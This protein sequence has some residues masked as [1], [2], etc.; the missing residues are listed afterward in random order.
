MIPAVDTLTVLHSVNRKHAAKQF[1]LVV[2]KKTGERKIKNRSYGLEKHFRVELVALESFDDLA[3]AFDRLIDQPFAFPI[4]GG[5]LPG[6]N[7]NHTPRWKNPRQGRPATF[8]GRAH[9]WFPVD[10]DKLPAPAL[11]DPTINPTDAIEY[12]IGKLPAECHDASAWFTFTSSQGLPKA[13]PAAPDLLSARVVFWSET[14]HTD[15]ELKRW[16]RAWNDANG[17]LKIIDPCLY[18]PIQACYIA[19]PSFINMADPLNKRHGIRRGLVDTVSLIIPPAHRKRQD[20]PGTEGYD[21]GAGVEHHLNQIGKPHFRDPIVK[22]I[23]SFVGSYG[24]AASVEELKAAIGKRIDKAVKDGRAGERS[25]DELTRYASDEH[26]DSIIAAIRAFQGDKPG[27]GFTPEPPPRLDEAPPAEPSELPVIRPVIQVA[28]GQLPYILDAAEEVLIERDRGVYAFGDQVVRPARRPIRIADDKMTTGLRLVPIAPAHM[29]ERF[30]KH[31]DFQKFDKRTEEWFSI[32]CPR[33]VAVAYLERI[34]LWH[35]PQLSAL[36][37]CPLLLP[38]DRI[39]D[40]PGFDEATGILFDAQGISFPSVKHAPTKDQALRALDFLMAPFR[41]F[42]FVDE[43]S[44]SVLRSLLLSS[45]SRFA[46]P[47]V[48]CHGFDAPAIGTG[49]S[50]L[51][52]CASILLT[53]REC[54]VV[55]QPDDEVEFEKKL[56]AILLAG[57]QL[58]SIVNCSYALDSPFMCMVLTQPYVQSRILGLSKTASIPNNALLGAN[59]CN[60]S[61]AGDMMRRGLTG[62]LDAGVEKPWEREFETEDPVIV[63]KRDRRRLVAA[64]LTVLRGYIAADRPRQGGAPLGGFEGWARLVRDAL[65]WLGAADP[66]LTI[67]ATR[68]ADPAR[69]KLETVVTQWRE[70]VGDR[71]LTTRAIIEEACGGNI[72]PTGGSPNRVAYWHPEFRNALLD[73]AADQGRVSADRLGKWIR[74]NLHKVVGQYR[75]AAGTL[76]DGNAR[77]KL[78]Q[79]LGDGTW[80]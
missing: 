77:W 61:F 22:A 71:T 79:R 29:A 30:T 64:A 73:V 60:F 40:K 47:F 9:H 14:P 41:D 68:K 38:D 51:F 33:T 76:R 42:P 2:N 8:G 43:A 53:A 78:E 3:A 69:Q 18:D 34:G 39:L 55:S 56:F 28:G 1:T 6:T 7:L 19:R 32:D 63:F 75:L 70:V 12:L 44:K 21:P 10:L 5:P 16:A 17:G 26:L 57:D 27:R 65:L 20:E 80:R 31:I 23:A 25:E 36:T 72:D 45:V 67:E 35:L 50:K 52:D 15:I 46:F 11:T 62:R 13:D 4:P 37:T 58:V 54:A 59:G 24:A 66:T 48:P 74:D 49:K